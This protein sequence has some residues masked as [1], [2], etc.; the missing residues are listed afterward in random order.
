MGENKTLSMIELLHTPQDEAARE[1]DRRR[2]SFMPASQQRGMKPKPYIVHPGLFIMVVNI[3]FWSMV[4][5]FISS[6]LSF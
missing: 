4:L 1:R 6:L 3:L 2:Y 5:F